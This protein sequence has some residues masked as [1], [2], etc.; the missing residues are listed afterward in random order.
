MRPSASGCFWLRSISSRDACRDGGG[1]RNLHLDH[2][3]SGKANICRTG[4][5]GARYA[6]PAPG[7]GYSGNRGLRQ[8]SLSSGRS[9]MRAMFQAKP[10]YFP[11]SAF[12]RSRFTCSLGSWTEPSSQRFTC[13]IET[14]CLTAG[15][16]ISSSR[17]FATKS[18]H[19]SF[20]NALD[21]PLSP[22]EGLPAPNAS[23]SPVDCHRDH[24]MVGAQQVKVL[25]MKEPPGQTPSPTTAHETCGALGARNAR[26]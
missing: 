17:T 15:S 26:S 11:S 6:A 7:N 25:S 5:A 2:A 10:V 23:D 4:G 19:S 22:L 24:L 12:S 21:G 20:R 8:T 16:R 1:S 9:T 18:V 14:W 3:L 13:A